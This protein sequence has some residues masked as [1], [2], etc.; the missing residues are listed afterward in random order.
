MHIIVFVIFVFFL[1]ACLTSRASG[2]P[3][4]DPPLLRLVAV[5]RQQCCSGCMS[6]SP[7][8]PDPSSQT[9]FLS[10]HDQQGR[11]SHGDG[12]REDEGREEHDLGR[13]GGEQWTCMI[14]SG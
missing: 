3:S 10:V 5:Q 1:K 8:T 6:D 7:V 14:C 9:R 4:V 11:R 13:R 12:A 2:S